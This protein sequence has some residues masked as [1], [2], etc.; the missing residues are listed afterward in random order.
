MH[1]NM[2]LSPHSLTKCSAVD[3]KPSVS[4]GRAP[5]TTLRPSATI[6]T[7]TLFIVYVL[8]WVCVRCNVFKLLF[9]PNNCT[10]NPRRALLNTR[11]LYS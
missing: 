5:A 4:E 9:Q 11:D 8:V 2:D 6:T 10:I 1:K 7:R 3:S